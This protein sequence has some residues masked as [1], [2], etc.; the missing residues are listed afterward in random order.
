MPRP[1]YEQQ[2][3]DRSR[4]NEILFL[5]GVR[6]SGKST[7]LLFK[8]ISECDKFYVKTHE[9]E[10]ERDFED[11]LLY[12]GFL[13]L[14][15]LGLNG[16]DEERNKRAELQ[17]YFDSILLRDIV[18]RYRLNNF[19]ILKNLSIFLLSSSSSV[20]SLSSLKAHFDLSYDIVN[21][22]IEYLENAF[23]IFSIPLFKWSFK[24]QQANPKKIYAIDTGLINTVS[25]QVGKRKGG[26][27]EN[28]VFIELK[29]RL[30]N[31]V[32]EIYYYKTKKGYEIDFLIKESD[33]ITHLIQVTK[34]VEENNNRDRELRAFAEA[35]EELEY[36]KDIKLLLISFETTKPIKYKNLEIKMINIFDW[37]LLEND[38]AGDEL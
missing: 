12:G 33:K 27:I 17:S 36:I 13:K 7:I 2:L 3:K 37:L 11:F 1:L 4:T 8:G 26:L 15:L 14:T 24:K 25:F 28:V 21:S 31:S 23:M 19:N 16:I 5:S 35:C 18:S 20:I 10:L 38:K 30:G 32:G 29:R 34:N 6:R 22:Y 9:L